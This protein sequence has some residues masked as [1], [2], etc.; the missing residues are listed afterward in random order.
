MAAAT[1]VRTRDSLALA[2]DEIGAGAPL[3]FAHG[4]SSN[5]QQTLEELLP[6]ASGLRIVAFDQRRHGESSPVTDPDLY[7]PERMADDIGTVMDALPNFR[8]FAV[9]EPTHA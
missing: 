6:L 1:L 7:D 3:V 9:A 8:A 5:R 4:L 2:V